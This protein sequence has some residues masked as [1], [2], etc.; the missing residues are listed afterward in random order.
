M[1]KFLCILVALSIFSLNTLV[2][3]EDV[4]T[5]CTCCN[6][7]NQGEQTETDPDSIP[8]LTDDMTPEEIY[9]AWL[10]A[11]WSML[12]SRYAESTWFSGPYGYDGYVPCSFLFLDNIFKVSDEDMN[13]ITSAVIGNKHDD[14]LRDLS[15]TYSFIKKMPS[16]AEIIT[17][18]RSIFGDSVPDGYEFIDKLM[19]D[20]VNELLEWRD[21]IP[22]Y[23]EEHDGTLEGFKSSIPDETKERINQL[24]YLFTIKG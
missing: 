15:K 7:Q 18:T 4:A 20:A 2:F 12:Y 22:K 11:S 3:A 23:M 16:T 21:S 1:K 5:N 17:S 8:G 14:K 13:N 6:C 24:N 19:M 9:E 10:T